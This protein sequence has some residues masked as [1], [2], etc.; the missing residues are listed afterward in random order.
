MTAEKIMEMLIQQN[1][2][3]K[4]MMQWAIGG[5]ITLLVVFLTANFF[6]MRN[7]RKSELENIKS[8]VK[9]DLKAEVLETMMPEINQKVI[10]LIG[11]KMTEVSELERT[12]KTSRKEINNLKA[13]VCVL[14]AEKAVPNNAFTQYLKAGEYYLAAENKTELKY[15]LEDIYKISKKMEYC[16]QS[17]LEGFMK[18]SRNVKNDSNEYRINEIEDNL[19]KIVGKLSE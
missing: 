16:F 17:E 19:K 11:D 4:N 12:V 2:D 1:Q 15:I 13:E 10:N 3:Y 14:K 7:V 9:N 8:E 6:T 18:F 5:I